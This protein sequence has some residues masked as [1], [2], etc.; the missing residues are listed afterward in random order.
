MAQKLIDRERFEQLARTRT[1]R[2]DGHRRWSEAT[3]AIAGAGQL[4]GRFVIEA[5]LSG[6]KVAVWDF[7]ETVLSNLGTQ[8]G[9]PGIAKV[10][11]LIARCDAIAPG[12]TRGIQADIRHAGIGQL[13]RCA[14]L[15][16]CTDD[17]ALE[18][19]LTEIS[20]GLGVARLR[21]AVDGTGQMEMG[22]V[23]CSHGGAGHACG[24][25][26]YAPEDL[27]GAMPRTLCPGRSDG[28]AP[29][30][31]GGALAMAIAGLGLLQAQ[32]LVTRND[33]ECV[34][35]RE[36]VLDLSGWQLLAIE[37][38]RSGSCLSGHLR[39]ELAGLG[40]TVEE[41]TPGDVLRESRQRLGEE[42]VTLEPYAHAL[43][44][45][46]YCQCGATRQ[47]VGTRWASPPQ[48][49][50]CRRPMEWLIETQR[51]RLRPDE[52]NELG[53]ERVP[54]SELGLPEGAMIVARADGK[55]PLRLVLG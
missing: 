4:G 42:Q 17:A 1:F 35:D 28:P 21:L 12:R 47:V 11:S 55:P 32:R 10:E 33:L 24:V 43:C 5:V 41:T 22:R 27:I 50:K 15:V 25:C 39:W 19:A 48:C 9:V 2:G 8:R 49:P 13:A 30:L 37:K 18:L 54:L 14:L 44:T 26:A 16:D 36:V 53:I 45:E 20:N 31:A 51:Q 46:V 7:D 29:T 3:L 34:I 40:R 6:T 52:L 38:R 23:S